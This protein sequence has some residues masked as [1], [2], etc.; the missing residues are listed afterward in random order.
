MMVLIN[1]KE[2]QILK[3][4][5]NLTASQYD[6]LEKNTSKTSPKGI[7]LSTLI[8]KR[9][10]PIYIN[11]IL[12]SQRHPSLKA[13]KRFIFLIKLNI[14]KASHKISQLLLLISLHNQEIG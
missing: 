14:L 8:H 2:P 3:L 11:I 5:R 6:I 9:I 7:L 13:K 1:C 12:Y 10:S 4:C